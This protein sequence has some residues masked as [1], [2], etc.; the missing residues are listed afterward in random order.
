MKVRVFGLALAPWRFL[1]VSVANFSFALS[2]GGAWFP[3]ATA[4]SSLLGLLLSAQVVSF[5]LL[6]GAVSFFYA[7]VRSWKPDWTNAAILLNAAVLGS[8]VGNQ[9]GGLCT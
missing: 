1:V 5:G 6:L 7:G 3:S 4:N 2:A 8:Y 9:L